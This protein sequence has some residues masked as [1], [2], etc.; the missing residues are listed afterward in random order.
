[1]SCGS[2]GNCAAGGSYRTGNDHGQGFV[3]SE[4]NGTWGT[5]IRVPGLAALNAGGPARV[6][7]VSCGQP[8]NCAAA[9]I[10]PDPQRNQQGFVVS[11]QDGTWGTATE[12]PGLALLNAGVAQ[13]SSVSCGP[14]GNCTVGGFYQDRHRHVQGFVAS[15][16]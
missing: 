7:S 16:S 12:V 9:G 4:R 10:Y 14:A 11:E 3:A 8:G 6:L 5:A 2:A 15:Q 13:A 1:M